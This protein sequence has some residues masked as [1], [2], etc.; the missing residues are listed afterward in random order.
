MHTDTNDVDNHSICDRFM[1]Y[2]VSKIANLD[3]DWT[4]HGSNGLQDNSE[5]CVDNGN[6]GRDCSGRLLFGCQ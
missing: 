1:G 2:P 3:V 4:A 6:Y 5:R